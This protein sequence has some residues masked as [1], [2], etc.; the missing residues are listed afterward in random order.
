MPENLPTTYHLQPTSYDSPLHRLRLRHRLSQT[1]AA[2]VAQKISDVDA[3][4]R[5]H[6]RE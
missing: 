3:A 1:S 5:T 4:W 2:S 6:R